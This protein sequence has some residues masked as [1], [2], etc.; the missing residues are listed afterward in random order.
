MHATQVLVKQ[1][2]TEK[3]SENQGQGKFTFIVN[4]SATK[5]DVKNAIK[6]LYGVD[7]AKVNMH[8][9]QGKS[10]QIGRGWEYEKRP[11]TKRAIITLKEGQ[12]LDPNKFV[13]KKSSK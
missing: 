2:V 6:S 5:V 8:I 12:K 11:K 9:V 10:R 4:K 1:L 13:F 7:V 3:A